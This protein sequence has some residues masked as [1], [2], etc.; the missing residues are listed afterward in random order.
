MFQTDGGDHGHIG[1][2]GVGGIETTTETGLDDADIDG[3]FGEPGEGHRRGQ[4]EIGDAVSGPLLIHVDDRR[5]LADQ[6]G[7]LLGSHHK[8]PDLEALLDR[9][10]MWRSEQPGG[11]PHRRHQSRTHPGRRRLAVGPGDMDD[12]IGLLGVSEHVEQPRDPLQTRFDP[13]TD[14]GVEVGDCFSVVRAATPDRIA[15]RRVSRELPR[16]RPPW[17]PPWRRPRPAPSRRSPAWRV[18]L[19][20]VR[21]PR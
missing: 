10:E 15:A 13:A 14:V 5:Q 17:R 20:S 19:A 18:S 7:E 8:A 1:V 12:R 4:L 16:I 6:L 21:G 3:P 9:I 2:G 11:E